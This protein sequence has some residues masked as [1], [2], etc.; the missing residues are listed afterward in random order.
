MADRLKIR[1]EL[2]KN[3]G[4]PTAEISD[5]E[6]EAEAQR[7]EQEAPTV[8]PPTTT[9]QPEATTAT[10]APKKSSAQET[11]QQAVASTASTKTPDDAVKNVDSVVSLQQ[12]AQEYL[13]LLPSAALTP[14]ERQAITSKYATESSKIQEEI[15]KAK[16]AYQAGEN[17]LANAELIDTLGK[18]LVQLMAGWYG[19]KTGKDAVT[20]VDFKPKDW[21]SN[22]TLLQK[23][24]EQQ[25]DELEK[26]GTKLEKA[27]EREMS[28]LERAKYLEAQRQE[29]AA[30]MSISE[31]QE[32]AREARAETKAKQ[33]EQETIKKQE[34][35]EAKVRDKLI[36]KANAE[37]G[38]LRQVASTGKTKEIKEAEKRVA[39]ALRAA[40]VSAEDVDSALKQYNPGGLF[41][42]ADFSPIENLITLP[43]SE[44]PGKM[45]T[46]VDRASGKTKQFP[47]NS[48]EVARARKLPETFEVK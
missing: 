4:V 47:A 32:E 20:G 7:Q 10:E 13:K 46:I 28:D 39:G 30:R 29:T 5:A 22:F 31:K 40:G 1:L 3:K 25:I 43:E 27:E 11:V 35:A 36:T 16:K 48:P 14:K 41:S 34:Q 37:I 2:A 15:D 42:K 18:G 21:S 12:K 9:A 44:E 24:Y 33:R 19:M 23:K 6:V 17:R 26:K 8:S 38:A 45:V